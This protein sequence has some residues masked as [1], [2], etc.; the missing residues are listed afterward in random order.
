MKFR[1]R[2][3]KLIVKQL[4]DDLVVYDE[5]DDAAHEL[6]AAAAAV[7]RRCD[8]ETDVETI[9]GELE[10][11]LGL[12]A[13]GE[14]VS[15]AIAELSR[16]KLLEPVDDRAAPAV[17]RRQL[18]GRLGLTGAAVLLLPLVETI[19]APTPAMAQSAPTTALPPVPTVIPTRPV[20]TT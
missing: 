8:G 6:N 17:S 20:P 7:W 11:E 18:V 14:V 13:D 4:G 10:A 5:L 3:E 16:A 12:P 19:V 15:L 1:A 2:S 9:A